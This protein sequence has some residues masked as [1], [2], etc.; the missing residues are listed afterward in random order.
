MNV[1]EAYFEIAERYLESCNQHLSN[2]IGIQE[3]IAFKCYHVFESLAGAFNSHFGHAIPK[4][5]VKKINLFVAVSKTHSRRHAR[6]I[7]ELAMVLSSQRNIYLYPSPNGTG[8]DCPKDKITVPQ[9]E[10]LFKR[11]R[12][13]VKVVGD[14]L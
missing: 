2:K 7:A 1:D 8:F 12:G 3:V 6:A 4:G 10:R 5:H 14:L 13:I 9:A 11:V